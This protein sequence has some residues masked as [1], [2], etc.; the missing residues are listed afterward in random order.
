[1]SSTHHESRAAAIWALGLIHEGKNDPV[2][3]KALE[4]RLNDIRSIPGEDNRVRRMSVIA[5]GRMKAGSALKSLQTYCPDR[6]PSLD[7]LSNACSW[8]ITQITGEPMPAAEPIQ[9]GSRDWFL[10]P[11]D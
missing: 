5:L 2:L 6:K 4:A 8:A 1:M 3:A 10:V 9:R 7:H 11:S